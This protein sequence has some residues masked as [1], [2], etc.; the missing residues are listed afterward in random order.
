MP[1]DMVMDEFSNEPDASAPD[2]VAGL[3]GHLARI[4][5]LAWEHLREA[6]R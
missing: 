5:E 2:Y 3:T 1:G 6:Q 4:K